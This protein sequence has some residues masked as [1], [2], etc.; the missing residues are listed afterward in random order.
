MIDKYS[1]ALSNVDNFDIFSD[2]FN[3]WVCLILVDKDHATVINVK[4]I[5]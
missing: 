1:L 3:L 2:N 4:G 5:Q